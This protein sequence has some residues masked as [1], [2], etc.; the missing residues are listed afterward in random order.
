[1]VLRIEVQ[2]Q[3]G[4]CV[5]AQC[6]QVVYPVLVGEMGGAPQSDRSIIRTCGTSMFKL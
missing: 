6:V 1:M 5:S 4:A 3:Y 2:A